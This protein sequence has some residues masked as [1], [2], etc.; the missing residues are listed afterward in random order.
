MITDQTNK[1]VWRWDNNDPLRANV[2][3]ED[4]DQDNQRFTFNPRF[5]GQYFDKEVGL[6]LQL[7]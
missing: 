2:P 7:M 5:P 6:T 1:V 3:D 4:P